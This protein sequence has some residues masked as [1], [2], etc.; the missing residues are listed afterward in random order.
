MKFVIVLFSLTALTAN[1]PEPS[2]PKSGSGAPAAS[3]THGFPKPAEWPSLRRTGTLEAHSPLKGKITDPKIAWK[4]YTG[5]LETHVVI[6]PGETKVDLKLPEDET[7]CA[8]PTDAVHIEDFIPN[9]AVEDTNRAEQTTVTY[10]DVLPEYPGKEKFEFESAFQKTMT[11]GQWPESIGRCF[12]KQNGEWIKVWESDPISDLFCP[13][14]IVGDFDKDGQQEV[15]V[16]PFYALKLLDAR[17]G[18]EKDYCKFND[19]RSYGFFGAYDFNHDGKT[20][21]L[22]QADFSKHVDV[23]GFGDDGKLKR[24]WTHSI[25]QN[26]AHP[27]KIFR[28]SPDPTSDIDGDGQPEVVT[29]LFN[30]TGDG[31]WHLSF[32]D[33]LTGKTKYDF[34]DEMFAAPLDIDGDGVPEILSTV[35]KGGS[36]KGSVRVRS[37]KGGSPRLLWENEHASWEKWEPNLPPNVKT[38][39]TLGQRTVLSQ[40]RDGRAYVVL[41]EETSPSKATLSIA[42]WNGSDLESRMSVTGD[43]LQALGLDSEG[44]LLVRSRHKFGSPGTLAITNGSAKSQHTI[45]SGFEPGP[46]V[47]A[48]PDDAAAPTILVQGSVPE[49]VAFQPPAAAGADV[50]L[51]HIPGRGQGPSYPVTF[52]PVVADLAGNGE[53]QLLVAEANAA[54]A[55]QM[56]ARNLDGEV[57]WQHDFP[58][59]AGSPPPANT[60]G[61]ILWQAGHFRDKQ[62]QDVLVTTQRSKM[63]SEET[64]LLSGEDGKLIW[65]REYQIKERAVGGN[66]FAIAD[67]DGDG[68][69]DIASLWPSVLY[70]LKGST[71]EDI[72]AIE[73]YWKQVYD[74]AVYFGQAVAGDFLNEGKPALFFSGRLMTGVIATDGTLKWFDALDKSA[75]HLPALGDC[76]GDGKLEMIG[77]GFDDGVR[78]Y[79][80]ATGEIKWRMPDPSGKIDGFGIHSANPVSGAVTADIDSDGRDEALVSMGNTLYCFASQKSGHGGEIR[81]KVELPAQ[82]GPPTVAQLEQEGS[83]SI[84]VVGRDGYVYCLR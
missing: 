13:L 6:E 74:K 27:Q 66:S 82:I 53:R 63:H 58:L 4:Q 47:V 3:S 59:I 7:S 15:A 76:D 67:Y 44:R 81:W 32:L 34:P 68:L 35:T 49:Q 17:T 46:A 75:P 16:L 24:L 20:E 31:K 70:I 50:Q 25:E 36:E 11:N 62:K 8:D 43:H 22:I 26:I 38:M 40:I 42:S 80:T 55:A 19:N 65:R 23:L 9:L 73:A 14:P 57:I 61:I 69:D 18:K 5:A 12:A 51:K 56:T 30:D 60:G 83:A 2:V 29:T 33:A 48:W 41:R 1:G 28:V 54:G 79:D 21:F 45:R 77:V 72:L 64:Y 52:G 37:V 39:A 84:L 71:G 10:A 78:C